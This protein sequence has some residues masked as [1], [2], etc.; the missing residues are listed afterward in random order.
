MRVVSHLLSDSDDLW[1]CHSVSLR[2]QHSRQMALYLCRCSA[3]QLR[4]SFFPQSS[5]CTLLCFNLPP[6]FHSS[7]SCYYYKCAL[8]PQFPVVITRILIDLTRHDRINTINWCP[9]AGNFN[10]GSVSKNHQLS[11]TP[12]SRSQSDK[13]VPVQRRRR[14]TV[15]AGY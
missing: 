1:T 15:R 8:M 11:K 6:L 7:Y 5:L 14:A 4:L 10:T 3:W 13:A 2:V 12:I 9:L